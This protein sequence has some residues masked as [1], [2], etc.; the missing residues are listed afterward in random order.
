MWSSARVHA[1]TYAHARIQLQILRFD[2]VEESTPNRKCTGQIDTENILI[3][4]STNVQKCT[5]RLSTFF[6]NFDR[7]KEYET[8]QRANRKRY[9]NRDRQNV[10]KTSILHFACR[11][12]LCLPS[13][14]TEEKLKISRRDELRN[15]MKH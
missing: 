15:N 13:S 8:E 5:K 7:R 10:L 12:S 3:S 2:K 6:I 11:R 14:L 4:H 9:K 1:N